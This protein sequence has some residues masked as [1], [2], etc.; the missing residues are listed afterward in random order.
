MM[1][2][3]EADSCQFWCISLIKN[4][5]KGNDWLAPISSVD[6][7]LDLASHGALVSACLKSFS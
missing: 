3:S 2:R 6:L 4:S 5:F 7:K 1:M